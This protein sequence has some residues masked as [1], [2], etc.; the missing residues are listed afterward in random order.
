MQLYFAC[1]FSRRFAVAS[2]RKPKTE[3]PCALGKGLN[4]AR[5][6]LN[7][8]E[9]LVVRLRE[10][11]RYPLRMIAEALGVSRGRVWQIYQNAKAK[12]TEHEEDPMISFASLDARVKK[13]LANMD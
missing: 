10:D 12:R 11:E 7:D 1:S 8:Q 4:P 13:C 2:F 5:K 9:E 3:M 6:L